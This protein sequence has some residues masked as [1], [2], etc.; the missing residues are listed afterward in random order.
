MEYDTSCVLLLQTEGFEE[1]PRYCLSLAVL[2]GC[3]PHCGS[4]L[5]RFLEVGYHFL[6]VCR[7]D[8]SGTES[9]FYIY[10]EFVVKQ[11]SDVSEAGLHHIILSKKLLN[12]SRLCRRLHYHKIF[13]FCHS[14]FLLLFQKKVQSK[15]QSGQFS[16]F[17]CYFCEFVGSLYGLSPTATRTGNKMTQK[18]AE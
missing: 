5:C 1:M 11:V 4:C 6:L 12:C 17:C 7:Y 2:I 9:A 3:K 15:V 14:L 16:K 10:A 13:S 18:S 8:I